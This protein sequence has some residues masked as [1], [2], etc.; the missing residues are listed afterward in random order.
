MNEIFKSEGSIE[1]G[2]IIVTTWLSWDSEVSPSQDV[3]GVA[4]KPTDEPP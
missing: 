4:L 3:D 2:V 1:I